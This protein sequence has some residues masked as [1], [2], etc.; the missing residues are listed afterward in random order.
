MLYIEQ[1]GVIVK[2]VLK[3]FVFEIS[4]YLEL[5]ISIIMAFVIF[6]LSIFFLIEVTN[7]LFIDKTEIDMTLFLGKAMTLAVGVEFIKMLCKHTPGTVIEVLLFAIARQMVV[8]HLSSLD[9]LVGVLSLAVLFATKK[10]LFCGFEETDHIIFRGSLKVKT[11][12]II[13][14]VKIPT[15]HGDNL[16]D[17]IK[18]YLEEK[19]ESIS[20]GSCVEFDD[21][22]MR[23]DSMKDKVITRVEIIK[24]L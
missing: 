22:A 6:T 16:R 7:G 20:I 15:E 12:N 21:F 10:Y 13:S 2:R 19:D 5:L 23:V 8:E 14:K 3:S 11:A 18:Y 4:Y 9:T 17:V 1:I 24:T